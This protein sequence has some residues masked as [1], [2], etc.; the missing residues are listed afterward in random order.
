M[1]HPIGV[2]SH[3]GF[4]GTNLVPFPEASNNDVGDH[5]HNRGNNQHHQ[6]LA[7]DCVPSNGGAA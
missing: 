4:T 5:T 2:A 7:H 6:K 1:Q 3:D